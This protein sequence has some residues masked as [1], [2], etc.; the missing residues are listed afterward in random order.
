[1]VSFRN[2]ISNFPC[3]HTKKIHSFRIF[4]LPPPNKINKCLRKFTGFKTDQKFL[5]GIFMLIMWKKCHI[6]TATFPKDYSTFH[7]ILR[8]ANNLFQKNDFHIDPALSEKKRFKTYEEIKPCWLAVVI[9]TAVDK[10]R[11]IIK[12]KHN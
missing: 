1:M 6:F 4:N 8:M 7:L 12:S 9:F 3:R 2:E 5:K 11:P 10:Y